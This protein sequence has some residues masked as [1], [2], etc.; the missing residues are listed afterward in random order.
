MLVLTELLTLYTP[1]Q[2]SNMNSSEVMTQWRVLSWCL[3]D[4]TDNH[5]KKTCTE[6]WTS[7]D[8]NCI[9]PKC[10]SPH[11][12]LTYLYAYVQTS[13]RILCL[14]DQASSWL[15]SKER[16]TWCHLLYFSLFNAQHV[17]DVKTTILRSLRLVCWVISWVLLIGFDVCWCYVVV[18]L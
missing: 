3:P 14:L 4:V 2:D 7:Q 8:S 12:S 15:L 16:P 9:L 18:W 6:N 5:H 17:S 1:D 10:K 13:H 11:I